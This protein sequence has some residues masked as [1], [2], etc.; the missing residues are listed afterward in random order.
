MN[1]ILAQ[2]GTYGI[3]PVVVLQDAAKAEPL[4]EILRVDA[5]GRHEFHHGV[6]CCDGT[7]VFQS[8]C[9]F[10]REEFHHGE[11]K[12]DRLLH[13]GRGHDARDHWYPQPLGTGR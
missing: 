3:V 9:R 4:A 1:Q 6:R 5:A 10:C 8:A 11:A 13:L 12:A 2:L 7:D